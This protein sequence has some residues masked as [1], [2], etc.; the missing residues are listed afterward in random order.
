MKISGSDM[1][2]NGPKETARTKRTEDIVSGIGR[3][4]NMYNMYVCI[5]LFIYSHIH[6]VMH[7]KP[8]Q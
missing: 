7:A 2:Y 5:C 8:Y 3:V 4:T 1:N 6:I